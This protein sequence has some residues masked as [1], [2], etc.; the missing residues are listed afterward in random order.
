MLARGDGHSRLEDALTR[1]YAVYLICLLVIVAAVDTI[2]DPPA[3]NP[4]NNHSIGISALH[5][6]GPLTLL[7]KEWFVASSSLQGDHL[8]WFAFKLGLDDRPVG[9]CTLPLVRLASDTSP[10]VFS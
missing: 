8:N 6:R 10:P 3:I 9:V 2:P 1:K 4:P 5:V 7:E